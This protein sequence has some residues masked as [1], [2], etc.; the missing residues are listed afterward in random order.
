MKKIKTL[1]ILSFILVSV[2][3]PQSE[4][5]SE[6][7]PKWMDFL[8]SPKFKKYGKIVDGKKEGLWIVRYENGQKKSQGTYKADEYNGKWTYWYENGQQSMER[9][10]NNGQEA[11][12]WLWWYPNEWW[13][14]DQQKSREVHFND[15]KLI[16]SKYFTRFGFEV[17]D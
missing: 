9:F 17:E 10:Y 5:E 12:V 11:G 1:L 6:Q 2:S 16:Y 7:L 4:I 15:G 14:K 8:S 13:H 3:S